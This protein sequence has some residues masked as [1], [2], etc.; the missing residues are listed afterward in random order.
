MANRAYLLSDDKVTRYI[1]LQGN[2]VLCAANYMVPIFWYALFEETDMIE[3][4]TPTDKGGKYKY[5]VYAK[6]V[7][8]AVDLAI[9][10]LPVIK[11][12]L[13][14]ESEKWFTIFH[15]YVNSQNGN[16]IIIDPCELTWM[17]EDINKYI[18]KSKECI[19]AFSTPFFEKKSHIF[20]ELKLTKPWQTLLGQANITEIGNDMNIYNLCGGE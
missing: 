7:K 18:K 6:K 14:G 20:K 19:R 15:K 5:P 2:K 17:D 4:S 12:N 3:M 16:L 9:S 13:K 1:D 8:N 10:R 11:E